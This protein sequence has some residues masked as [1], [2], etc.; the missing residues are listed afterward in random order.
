[1]GRWNLSR[2]LPNNI[3]IDQLGF[4]LDLRL[5]LLVSLVSLVFYVRVSTQAISKASPHRGGWGKL[6]YSFL[7]MFFGYMFISVGWAPRT[8]IALNKGLDLLVVVILTISARI[9][10]F[11]RIFDQVCRVMHYMMFLVASILGL[12]GL[13]GLASS[14]QRLAVLGGG[15]NVYGRL[16]GIGGL[17]GLRFTN[18]FA[19]IGYGSTAVFAS[20]VLLTGSRGAIG[21]FAVAA[22]FLFLYT[23]S[24]T[25][26]RKIWLLILVAAAGTFVF[27]FTEFGIEAT[28]RFQHR[29]LDL[30]FEQRYVAG[31][32]TL[33]SMAIQLWQEHPVFGLGLGGWLGIGL[34][35]YPHN[36]FLEAG[37]EGG[38]IGF[39]LLFCSQMFALVHFLINRKRVNSLFVS[40]WLLYFVSSQ[41]SGDFFDSRNVFLFMVIAI[42]ATEETTR[43]RLAPIIVKKTDYN[44]PSPNR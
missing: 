19:W 32:D 10:S 38:S 14:G 6:A 20:L 34:E 2:I 31:R 15:P 25:I 3:L 22:T 43:S 11:Q 36:M 33:W 42:R 9:I 26:V 21:A 29:V 27:G 8:D 7:L 24:I 41:A 17:C 39:F 4:L 13:V 5:I 12:M 1:V 28:E 23:S 40:L 37:C 35:T 30:T 16:V 18:S 44:R